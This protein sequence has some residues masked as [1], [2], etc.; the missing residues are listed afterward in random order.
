MKKY[1]EG[2]K[3]FYKK[4]NKKQKTD[5]LRLLKKDFSIINCNHNLDYPYPIKTKKIRIQNEMKK[6][7][8]YCDFQSKDE[9]FTELC[10]IITNSQKIKL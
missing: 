9:A 6:I 2:V 3:N 7:F 8:I 4:L 1:D 10:N 5:M